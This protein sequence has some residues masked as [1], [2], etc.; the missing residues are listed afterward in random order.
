MKKK[1]LKSGEDSGAGMYTNFI[2]TM[3]TVEL[4]EM[5]SNTYFK[6]SSTYLMKTLNG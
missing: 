5:T 4:Q 6:T 3:H 1:S 2:Q